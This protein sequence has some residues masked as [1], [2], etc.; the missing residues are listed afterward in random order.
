MLVT[1]A[2]GLMSGLRT[3]LGL[4][5]HILILGLLVMLG[6]S[7]LSVTF[8]IVCTV[9][10]KLLCEWLFWTHYVRHMDAETKFQNWRSIVS[11]SLLSHPNVFNS[12][13][14][15]VMDSLVEVLIV[16]A[17]LKS[18]LPAIWVFLALYGCQMIA[19]PIQGGLSDFFSQKK[20]LLFAAFMGALALLVL[21]AVPL[22]GQAQDRKSVV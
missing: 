12:L 15:I 17:A 13:S 11:S 21:I 2:F 9:G 8:L 19:A 3:S 1:P 4:L 5:P 10:A 16:S 18:S 14:M 22:D 7:S 6:G 20:S